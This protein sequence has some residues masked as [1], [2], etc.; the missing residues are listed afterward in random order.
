M[1]RGLSQR[2]TVALAL[3]GVLLLSVG[4]CMLPAQQ[5][6]HCCCQHMHMSMP[7]APTSANC[8]AASPQTPPAMVTPE[9]AGLDAAIVTQVFAPAGQWSAS[10]AD[11]GV[12]ALATHSP[13]LGIF[14]LRI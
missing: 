2:I 14:N 1:L 12:A 4:T 5:A 3:M 11:D 10:R 13:P 7:C 8:C 6:T 9:F